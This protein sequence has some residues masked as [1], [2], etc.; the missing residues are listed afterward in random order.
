MI[1]VVVSGLIIKGK[2]KMPGGFK[3]AFELQVPDFAGESFTN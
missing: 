2:W 1:V 3:Q